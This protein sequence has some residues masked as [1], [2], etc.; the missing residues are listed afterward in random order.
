MNNIQY[1]LI[2][3]IDSNLLE[4]TIDLICDEFPTQEIKVTEVGLY[5]GRTSSGLKEYIESKKRFPVLTGVDNFRDKEELVFYPK[6]AKLI[7]GNS[8]EVYNEIDNYSQHLIIIDALH[9]LA[10]VISDF[11][12]YAPKVRIGGFVAFH[13]A[14]PHAQ[15]KSYQRMG[16]EKDEDMYISVLRALDRIGL[17]SSEEVRKFLGFELAFHEWATPDID[18]GGGMIVFKKIK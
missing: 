13:D 3:R 14:A 7:N 16:S 2:S 1:G 11:Y 8:T 10:G 18:D 5:N 12:C 4:K 9:T 6:E 15:N 17:T